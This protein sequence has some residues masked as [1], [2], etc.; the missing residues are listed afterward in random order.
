[1]KAS[2][3]KAIA[4]ALTLYAVTAGIFAPNA[5]KLSLSP[6]PITANADTSYPYGD[7][8]FTIRSRNVAS[9][10]EYTGTEATP[11]IPQSFQLNGRTYKITSIDTNAFSKNSNIKRITIPEGYNFI[12]VCAFWH[13]DQLE[14]VSLPSS[15]KTIYES[16][17]NNCIKLKKI[18]IPENVYSIGNNAFIYCTSLSEVNF[19][20]TKITKLSNEIFSNCTSLKSIKIPSSVTN[21]GQRSFA[22]CT[23][24]SSISFTDPSSVK[25]FGNNA[26]KN[27]PWLQNQPRTNGLVIKNGYIIDAS[28]AKGYV[29][30]PDGIRVIPSRLFE[31]NSDVTKISLPSSVV[32]L[33][34]SA[35]SDCEKLQ[36]VKL[37][38]SIS[39][40]PE[41]CFSRCTNLNKITL[42]NKIT[43]IGDNAFSYC[44]NL[45]TINF[46]EYLETVE[47]RAFSDCSSLNNISNVLDYKS[48]D[49]HDTAF[50]NCLDLK[51]INGREFAT[52]SGYDI[53]LYKEKFVKDYFSKLDN[54]G[55]I[56]DFI[57]KK[58]SAVVEQIKNQHPN[59][60]E[61]QL[62]LAL[63]EWMCA[64]GCSPMEKWEEEHGDENYPN[65]IEYWDEYHRESSILLN[66]VGVCEGWAKGYKMLLDKAGIQSEI[67]TSDKVESSIGLAAHAWNV[68]KKDGEWFN[69]DT[70]WDDNGDSSEQKLFMISDDEALT[71]DKKQN[72]YDYNLKIGSHTKTR[73][74]VKSA[75][76]LYGDDSEII[77][78]FY[79]TKSMG[80][81]NVD[82]KV[83]KS[84]VNVLLSFIT[85]RKASGSFDK[86]C[87]DMNFDE[88]IDSKDLSLLKQKILNN[89]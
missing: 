30:I 21:I 19:V 33:G 59:Y 57:D 2:I 6:T 11:T 32:V 8:I 61:P 17:F 10:T 43:K 63:E 88:K 68:I 15:L 53:I 54:V 56:Q 40:I 29:S 51:K 62:A 70:Y 74:K 18:T 37:S 77:N 86:L 78:R 89:K 49:I 82:G 50:Y 66:G 73:V 58:T 71:I 64:N 44:T 69:I 28:S 79:C 9:L 24:L 23:N 4:F 65:D 81:V 39:E 7:F 85:T 38:D 42:T 5:G 20:T 31:G 47:Y 16:A 12:D 13:C 45:K 34:K 87:A 67:V 1:M 55:Y 80:D 52:R 48:Y 14:S 60:T 35:F 27:T 75:V 26:F 84:D 25:E 72:K 36:E 3:K 76:G 22:D 46:P 41:S 83:N